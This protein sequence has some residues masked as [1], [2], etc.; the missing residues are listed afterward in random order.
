MTSI[1]DFDFQEYLKKN[2]QKNTQNTFAT[3]S[4]AYALQVSGKIYVSIVKK[5]LKKIVQYVTYKY[6]EYNFQLLISPRILIRIVCCKT[7]L[8]LSKFVHKC[9]S[10]NICLEKPKLNKHAVWIYT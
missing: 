10:Q 3:F 7:W 9:S 1:V 4:R 8:L 5:C 6:T 2:I